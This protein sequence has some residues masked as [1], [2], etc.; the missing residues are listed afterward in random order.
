MT[1][2]PCHLQ[3]LWPNLGNNS[4][5]SVKEQICIL[6]SMVL[7]KLKDCI[8][9]DKNGKNVLTTIG[10][11]FVAILGTVYNLLPIFYFLKSHLLPNRLIFIF[12]HWFS[13]CNCY[14]A[15]INWYQLLNETWLWKCFTMGG[16]IGKA[17]NG[18]GGVIG[19]A[20]A[21]PT[22]LWSWK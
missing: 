22:K 1:S 7:E 9:N 12:C 17:A 3:N 11:N 10:L 13:Q 16:V 15:N 6:E 5:L 21:A 19:S 8:F 14:G 2:L 4:G 20:F 18:I